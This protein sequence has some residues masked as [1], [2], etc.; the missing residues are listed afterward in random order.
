LVDGSSVD[1]SSFDGLGGRRIVGR[2]IGSRR[3][4]GRRIVGRRIEVV[5]IFLCYGMLYFK[6]LA[7]QGWIQLRCRK[8]STSRKCQELLFNV[9]LRVNQNVKNLFKC[10]KISTLN[11]AN[12]TKKRPFSKYQSNVYI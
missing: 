6:N 11:H 2:R 9:D 1:G 5:P 4:V 8:S 10:T 7:T 12:I 3:I